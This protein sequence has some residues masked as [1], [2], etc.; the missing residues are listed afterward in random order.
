MGLNI[1]KKN[2]K[3]AQSPTTDG[4]FPDKPDRRYGNPL[5]PDRT[6]DDVDENLANAIV[7]GLRRISPTL[8]V[9]FPTIPSIIWQIL[10]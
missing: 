1:W 8:R 7:A 10:R 3:N 6:C 9:R 5:K 4:R 2:S